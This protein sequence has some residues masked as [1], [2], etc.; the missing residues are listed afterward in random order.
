M[1]TAYF[2]NEDIAFSGDSM[3]PLLAMAAAIKRSVPEHT[4]HVRVLTGS[5]SVRMLVP[6][7]GSI[8]EV[9]DALLGIEV[10]AWSTF[11]HPDL[12]R[13][14]STLNVAAIVVE[15]VIAIE[16]RRIH[17]QLRATSGYLG[18]IDSPVGNPWPW[19]VYESSLPA[20]FRI[21]GSEVRLFYREWEEGVEPTRDPV[22]FEVFHASRLFEKVSWEDLG[23]R[24]TVFDVYRSADYLRMRAE[25]EQLVE[26]QLSS[27]VNEILLRTA[28]LD[29]GILQ[30]VHGAF[31]AFESMD[32]ADSAAHIAVSCRRLLERTADALYPA[33]SE[34]VDGRDVG[35][36]Q[37]IN[38]LWA[39][40]N[41]ALSSESQKGI[42]VSLI[43]D[44]GKRIDRLY[45][46]SNR[47]IHG[48][49]SASEAR[50]LLVGLTLLLYDL[51]SLAELPK[52][53]PE[54]P[55]NTP[56]AQ[57]LARSILLGPRASEGDA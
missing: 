55:Y 24:D 19:V 30:Y 37:Y 9:M 27:V 48:E 3:A 12:V 43:N 25:T 50:R 13:V 49:M 4:R 42:L 16:A 8:D 2:F 22:P 47:G 17:G 39:Y 10:P 44:L 29:P 7:D 51:L 46:G 26:G 23:V 11:T 14:F 6:K 34:T 52:V 36:E 54:A 41:T 33:R 28:H 31:K 20:R 32:N 40:A 18:A 45:D 35:K 38:R 56:Q 5:L 21:V 15:G 57:A 1:R 53:T